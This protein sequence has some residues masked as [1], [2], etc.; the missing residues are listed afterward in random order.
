MCVLEFSWVTFGLEIKYIDSS[1][2][3]NKGQVF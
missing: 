1:D 2:I 3:R